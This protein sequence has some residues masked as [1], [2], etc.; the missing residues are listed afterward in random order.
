MPRTMTS[1]A[2]GKLLRNFVF[3]PFLEKRQHPERQTGPGGKAE[4]QRRQ[5]A[6][7]QH[8]GGDKSDDAEHHRGDH[9]PSLRPF[10]SRLRQPHG[11]RRALGLFPFLLDLLQRAFDLFAARLLR[12]PRRTRRSARCARRSPRAVPPFARRRAA[13]KRTPTPLRRSRAPPGRKDRKLA[14][15]RFRLGPD[16]FV[17]DFRRVE[18]GRKTRLLAVI[19]RAL[20]KL[21]TADAGR[22]VLADQI[23][24]GVLAEDV[25]EER[26][27]A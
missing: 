8:K 13:D 9:E 2:S 25:V 18:R 21:R 27:P 14:L 26:R 16:R 17:D 12:R 24:V 20:P 5:K 7:S 10:E 15:L 23:A 4:A 11:E 1:T 6:Q 19:A 22:P 3:A